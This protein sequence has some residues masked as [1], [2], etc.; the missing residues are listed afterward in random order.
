MLQPSTRLF[1]PPHHGAAPGRLVRCEKHP[2][3]PAPSHLRPLQLRSLHGELLGH[4]SPLLLQRV[5]QRFHLGLLCCRPPPLLVQ[6]QGRDRCH[7]QAPKP[8]VSNRRGIIHPPRTQR[9]R[10]AL[11]CS[12]SRVCS[13]SLASILAITSWS[14][15]RSSSMSLCCCDSLSW[16]TAERQQQRCELRC[17][18]TKAGRALPAGAP[19]LW[20]NQ[21]NTPYFLGGPRSRFSPGEGQP[22][23]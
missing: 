11:T 9:A 8:R 18:T 19:T 2:E 13:L 5:L 4:D 6:A 14:R 20:L 10:H 16:S 15:L 22:Y 3:M 12:S 17:P 23:P 1:H 21:D 7:S